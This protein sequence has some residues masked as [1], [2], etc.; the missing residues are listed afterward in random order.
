MLLDRCTRTSK[1]ITT[2]SVHEATLLHYM[3]SVSTVITSSSNEVEVLC[4]HTAG[5][6][7]VATRSL[8]LAICLAVVL[9]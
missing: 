8:R 9:Y 5:E 1:S 7:L 2:S 3:Y 6:V 4:I